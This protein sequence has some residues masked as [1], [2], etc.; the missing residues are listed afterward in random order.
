MKTIKLSTALLTIAALFF[1]TCGFACNRSNSNND[2]RP[3][4]PPISRAQAILFAKDIASGLRSALPVVTN[5]KPAAG[6]VLRR[7]LPIADQVIAAIERSDPASTRDLL[8]QLIPLTEQVIEQFTDNATVL[9]FMA[10][11]DIGIHFLINHSDQIFGA[12]ATATKA[13]KRAMSSTAADAV[14]TYAQRPAW[15]CEYH[16]EKCKQ[17]ER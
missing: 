5:L 10:L 14:T 7:A 3:P 17:L 13:G 8:N 11:A 6:E 4:D 2:N 15:G 12:A 16:P 1:V 9:G